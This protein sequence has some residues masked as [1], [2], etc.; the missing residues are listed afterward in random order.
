MPDRFADDFL[1]YWALLGG[2][3]AFF[4]GRMMGTPDFDGS[5]V[6]VFTRGLGRLLLQQL[7]RVPGALRRLKVSAQAPV[8]LADAYD[9]VLSPVLSHPAPRIGELGPDVPFRTH[10]AR[11]VRYSCF[12]PLANITGAP[13]LSLPIGRTSDGR[14]IGVQAC[15]D[16]GREA[17]LLSLGYELEEA[18]PWPRI[19]PPVTGTFGGRS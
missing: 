5:K 2:V 13:A 14:P 7:E 1:R 4:G 17:T 8:P 16:R 19:A 18:L 11:L 10:L 12:T 3:L 6:E 15:A 9:V